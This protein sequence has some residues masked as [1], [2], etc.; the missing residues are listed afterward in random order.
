MNE[1][2]ECIKTGAEMT[3]NQGQ[4]VPDNVESETI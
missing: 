2:P 1:Q 3:E 4:H